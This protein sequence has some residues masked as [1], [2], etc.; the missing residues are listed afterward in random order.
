MTKTSQLIGTWV[1]QSWYNEAADGT[2]R[3]PLGRDAVGYISYAADG[4]VFVHI[5]AADRA[6]FAAQDPFGGTEAE[7]VA[8]MKSHLT[9]AG[10]YQ[11]LG[12]RAVHSVTTSS[13]PNWVGSE[14]VRYVTLTG[15]RLQL[16]ALRTVMQGERITAYW[17]WTRAV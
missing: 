6:A 1:L 17:N 15:D 3:Y 7:D 2:R 14:Q 4:F 13:C 9:Y 10:R 5:M 16:R 11:D 8:A 12:D